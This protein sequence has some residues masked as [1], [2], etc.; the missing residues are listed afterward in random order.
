MRCIEKLIIDDSKTMTSQQSLLS[1]NC[2]LNSLSTISK[3]YYCVDQFNK[4]KG[5]SIIH[6]NCQSI[7]KK[8]EFVF[9]YC[10]YKPEILC[11]SESWLQKQHND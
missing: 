7:V 5:L 9:F 3:F 4:T 11:I 6:I 10:V 8:I 1:K 2:N